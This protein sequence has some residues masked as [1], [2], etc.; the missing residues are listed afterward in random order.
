MDN[1]MDMCAEVFLK[2][3]EKLFGATVVSTV[4]EAKEFLEECSAGVFDTLEEVREFLEEEGMDTCDLSDEELS[5]SLEVFHLE[6]GR[7]LVVV[8]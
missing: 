5:E 8:A 7:F 4:E 3:H 2:E 6:N 1:D